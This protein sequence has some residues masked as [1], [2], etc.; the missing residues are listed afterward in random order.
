VIG[1]LEDG[2]R[3]IQSLHSRPIIFKEQSTAL[4]MSV[5]ETGD[6]AATARNLLILYR[7]ITRQ[8]PPIDLLGQFRIFQFFNLSIRSP[9]QLLFPFTTLDG[10]CCR[11]DAF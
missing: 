6:S 4:R 11:V 7:R 5:A 2:Y 10:L 9:D 3:Q 8:A 1:A